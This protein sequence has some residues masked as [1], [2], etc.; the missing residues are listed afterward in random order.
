MIGC[1][2]H[3]VDVFARLLAPDFGAAISPFAMTLP[4]VAELAFIAWLLVKAVRIPELD[5]RTPAAAH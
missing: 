4:A 1:L 5:T 3:L 2:G